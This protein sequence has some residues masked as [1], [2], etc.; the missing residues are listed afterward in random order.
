M[1]PAAMPY[2]ATP[3]VAMPYDATPPAAMPPAAPAAQQ[4][5]QSLKLNVDYP[6]P[7]HWSHQWPEARLKMYGAIAGTAFGILV[8][9]AIALIAKK[10]SMLGHMFD[11]RSVATI[12]PVSI[13]C[14]FFWS[15]ALCGLR[16]LRLRSLERVSS[17]GLL[18]QSARI[19]SSSGLEEL[20]KEVEAEECQRS[21]LL[22]RLQAIIRQW[23][24]RPSL[25]DA[26]L[27][28]QQSVA[29]DEESVRAGYNLLRTFIWALPVLGLIGTV[30]GISVAVGGFAQFL[31]GDID[32][33]A[34][35]KKNLVGVTGGLSF[36]F[37]ITL[38]GLLTALIVMLATSALQGREEKL[39]SNIQQ[40]ITDIF[41]PV[42]QAEAPEMTSQP[43]AV[44]SPVVIEIDAWRES[45]QTVAEGALAEIRSS[46][47]QLMSGMEAREQAH[48][49]RTTE[50]TRE[51]NE[52]AR[53]AAQEIGRS[54]GAVA[55]QLQMVND[56]FLERLALVRD[57]LNQQSARLETLWQEQAQETA[58]QRAASAA[59]MAEQ[60]RAIDGATNALNLLSE[61]T[62]LALTH[63]SALREAIR[64]LGDSNLE[65]ALISLA[66]MVSQQTMQAQSS[67]QALRD[68]AAVT[69]NVLA[70]QSTLQ[71]AINQMND[72]G[73]VKTLASFRDSLASIA[74][75][76][77]SFREPFVLQAVPAKARGE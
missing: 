16:W 20:S 51:I 3:P 48:Y 29:T 55:G 75:T 53:I 58:Q 1:P 65:Q 13:S 24:I 38:Q 62:S 54:L 11:L 21:P 59:A 60:I 40:E 70:S 36:A 27:V 39:Y 47:V 77:A 63:H 26:D 5:A 72:A 33:V 22:R 64:H 45:L 56:N 25:Q 52:E 76:L 2:D 18:L 61:S 4:A 68:M 67:A 43:A 73:L 35:I 74:P 49:A 50:L 71:A 69:Q 66:S 12:I 10:E 57:S 37:I 14:M 7:V 28:L 34:I 41:L 31:G 8:S 32:D 6:D 46:C 19:L 44:P 23:M 42:L 9:L 15:V 30:I 17:K